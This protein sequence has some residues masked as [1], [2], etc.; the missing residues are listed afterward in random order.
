MSEES[1]KPLK[2]FADKGMSAQWAYIPLL[3]PF[4]GLQV[5]STTP[6]LD[7]AYTKHGWDAKY[8]ELVGTPQEAEYIVL[9]HEYWWMYENRRDLLE[10]Y[11]ELSRK[12][13][14]PL[15]VDAQSDPGGKVDLPDA[16][17]LR[18]NQY[19]FALPNDE[20][21]APYAVEDLLESYCGGEIQI[22]TKGEV[23]SA[24]F[25]GFASLTLKQRVRSI[26][27]ELPIRVRGILDN[28]YR[29][30]QRGIFWRERAMQVFSR[31]KAAKVDFLVRPSY[32]GHVKTVAGDMAQNRR[33]FVDNL[34]NND[35]ALVVRGDPNASQR[36]YEV[37]SVGRIPVVIDTECVFPLEDRIN[38]QDFCVLID[39]RDIK[40]APE[41]LRAFHEKL[42]QDEFAR[43][44]LR[45]REVYEKYLRTDSFTKY[46]VELLR[47]PT[48]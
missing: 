27:K 29:A 22:R 13:G 19:R 24:G 9:P 45:A 40:K 39:F 7:A 6:Y 21:T 31:S 33:Q 23:P 10:Q 37:L 34:L 32:S 46:L 47:K 2:I 8:F 15:L 35:Y 1:I 38:Y 12:T 36:F 3:Y 4:W 17:I 30:M 25:A 43:M 44:Q 5:K 18:T 42:S 26:L 48:R 20:I 11:I 41:L 28:R 16:R 14:V